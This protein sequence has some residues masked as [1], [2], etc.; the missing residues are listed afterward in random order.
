[1]K[2]KNEVKI[3]IVAAIGVMLLFFGM[4]FLKGLD[5]FSSDNQYKMKFSD[6]TG[7]SASSPI[8]A[9][10][11]RVGTVKAIDYDFNRQ[12]DITVDVGINKDMQIPEGTR[13]EIVS[14]LLGN[15]Q[16]NLLM[17]RSV[18]KMLAPGGIIDGT[19][20]DGAMGQV[21]DMV[22]AI[23]KMLP[24]LD[25][26]LVSVNTLLADPNIP[27]TLHNVNLISSDLTN[28]TKQLNLLLAQLNARMPQLLGKTDNLLDNASSTMVSANTMIGSLNG[29]VDSLN[30]AQTMQKVQHTL[31][32]VQQ[33]TDK[34]NNSNGSLGLLINDNKL[35]DNLNNTVR[36]ADSLLTN[37][38]AHPKR[39]VHFSIFGKKDK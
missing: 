22:P 21:K 10:G 11:Y 35:Y 4:T 9:D 24:K 27:A 20:N 34:I 15:V 1:M 2:I 36:D 37:L 25:S 33:L 18:E 28:S 19:I 16:V 14:D 38:K 26:I 8:Y 3:G 23:K 7:L 17:D 32:N 30:M 13:A 6:I 12:G 31:D 29:K 39:Y 5:I